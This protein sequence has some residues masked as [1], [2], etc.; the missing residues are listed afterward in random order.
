MP[1]FRLDD[2]TGDHPKVLRAG[3][4]GF[5]LWVRCGTHCAK[6]LT[7]GFV[8]QAVALSKGPQKLIDKVTLSEL[9]KK[10]DGGYLIED[11]LDYNPS[12]EQVLAER[13]RA[14]ERQ[15]R[16]RDK[17]AA[18][19]RGS[20]GD[21]VVTPSSSNPVSHGV[22]TL[23]THSGV[24]SPPYPYPIDAAAA[25]SD[26]GGSGSVDLPVEVDI[27]R[28]KMAQFT[29][30]SALRW[31]VDTGRLDQIRTLIDLH[32][33][34]RLVDVAVRTCRTPPPVSVSA[35]IGTWNALP[36]P[37]LTMHVIAGPTCPIC[38]LTMAAC[39]V[40]DRKSRLP[41]DRCRPSVAEITSHQP[42]QSANLPT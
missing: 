15:A 12:R 16:A 39:E 38:S 8:D 37:G 23:V 17:A 18:K 9:W 7:D 4:D 33:D 29:A 2:E 40:A 6:Y 11:Y 26:A 22:T 30:F 13:A 21:V 34:Q 35:F 19:R 41:E 31:D 10:V 27:L 24:T 20:R 28:S 1:W 42:H 25:A 3:N 14:A 5:G 36:P 32:G